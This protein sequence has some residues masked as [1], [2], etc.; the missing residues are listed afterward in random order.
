MSK[1]IMDQSVPEIKVPILKPIKVK[2]MPNQG[3]IKKVVSSTQEQLNKFADWIISY[4]PQEVKKPFNKRVED[5]KNT[6]NNIYNSIKKETGNEQT[7]IKKMKSALKGYVSTY[8]IEGEKG[9]DYKIFLDK[10][11]DV[12]KSIINKIEKPIKMNMVLSESY[13]RNKKGSE[14]DSEKEFSIGYFHSKMR[15]ITDSTDL[16]KLYDE[17]VENISAGADSYEGEKS[18]WVHNEVE[19]LD[20]HIDKYN[21]VSAKSYIKLPNNLANKKAIINLEN[22]D[23]QCFK[24]SVSRALFQEKRDNERITKKLKDNSE[25][26]CWDGLEF[27]VQVDKIGIFEKNN[28]KYA[29]NVYAYN[30]EVYPIRISENNNREQTINLLLISDDKTNHYCWIKNMSRLINSQTSKRNHRRF[31]C[32]RCLL[33]FWNQKALDDHSEYCK[34]YDAVK[35]TLPEKGTKLTFKNWNHSMRVPFVIYADF[36]CFTEK[37]NTCQPKDDKSFT[38]QYQKHKPS[39]FC[40]MVKCYD[41][42]LYKPTLHKYTVKSDDEDVG[43]KFVES[44]E[45]T[46]RSIYNKYN[47]KKNVTMTKNDYLSYDKATICHICDGE[48]NG[49][50]VLDHDHLTGRYRGAAHNDC[51]LNFKIPKHIPVLFHNLAG[52]DAHLFIK[53]L[54]VS[55]GKIGCIP[56][57]EEKYISFKKD[58]KVDDYKNKDGKIINIY[59]EIRFIDSFKFMSSKLEKLVDNLENDNFKNMKQ[60]YKKKRLKL[61]LK[62]GVYPYD[63]ID[64]FDK[65]NEKSL[66]SIEAFFSKLNNE[67]ISESDYKH[68]QEVWK[69]FNIKN[70]KE[71][72]NLY[73]E[74]DVI[75]LSDVFETFR[76]VCIENYKLDPA[77][78]Y[79]SPG[80]SWDAMLKKTK[81]NLELLS[82]P[83]MLLMIEKGIRGG[84]SMISKRYANANNK[85][86]TNYDKKKKSKFIKYLD[87]NNLYGWAMCK[88]LPTHGFEWMKNNDLNN[89]RK[90]PCI[91]E[92]D[93]DYP[94]EL[95]NLHNEYPLAPER[96]MI[97]KV[98]KLTPNLYD[99]KKYVIHHETLKLYESLGLKITNIHRGIMFKESNW[100]EKYI[101]LNT[102]LRQK[103]KNDFEK[104][105]FKLMNNCIY[106]KTME[107]IRNRQVI[108]LVTNESQA[109]KLINK[110]NYKKR[111]IFSENLVAVHMGK[112]ELVFNKPIYVGMAIVDQSKNLMYDFHYNYIKSKYGNKAQLLFTDTDSLMY[113]IET[114]DF[115]KDIENDIDSKFDTSDYPEDHKG[116]KKRVNKK[117]IGM[118]KDE[119]MGIEITE[120]VGLRAKLYSYKTDDEKVEKRC[121]GVKKSVVKSTISFDDYK[122]CL[123]EGT[124]HMRKMNV[125]RSHKHQI[126]SETIN[127][128]ALSRDDN[129]RNIQTDQINTLAIGYKNIEE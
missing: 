10:K 22:K 14:N 84:I 71:Y 91:L 120:F 32:E 110:P 36:E 83:D 119:M 122:N 124:Q 79:T 48:L 63:Y 26:I 68:A 58:I 118:M 129:K 20:I 75:L 64:S 108:N 4:V 112:T 101:T 5:L 47:Y 11:R 30:K 116:V 105:F 77:W 18:F 100:L 44:L 19:N 80:L 117:V 33:S 65:L 25:N 103:A 52:Y 43:E 29:I 55:S 41:D 67:S 54:G 109:A 12:F 51:N 2:N 3:I 73:L 76:D 114:D 126:Y 53:N 6:V 94:I 128:V 7:S 62:K 39:G 27:P 23:N 69:T 9:V 111:T 16:D 38:Q 50:K 95:H 37:I 49:D 82:D 66:P 121:K 97:N 40:Y 93:L 89:W 125:I 78:Y 70:M 59:R 72:H 115:Y 31:Y 92:V 21:P 99:K 28:P 35:I 102:K 60:F 127:K 96:L 34:D 74:S 98:E 15:I 86:M 42:N 87:A 1:N 13:K 113:E 61:L 106:G 81:I 46:V 57:N 88:N 104:D 17:C 24:W 45:N 123:F 90:I 8:R 107:N 56:N 85:Y